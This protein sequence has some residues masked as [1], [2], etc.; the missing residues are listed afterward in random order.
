MGLFSKR[1][2]YALSDIL[3][4][5]QDAVNG[6]QEMLQAQ[7]VQNLKRFWQGTDGSPICQK[8][9]IG[10][11]EIDVPLVSLVS[12]NHLEMDYVEVMFKARIADVESHSVV[13]RL[14]DKNSVSY[15]GLQV[16][17]D[18]LEATDPDMIDITV[19]F[20]LKD[21]AEGVNQLAHQCN[22]SI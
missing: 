22:K 8:V 18:D 6:V 5:L 10:N 19:R 2:K 12:H 17:L 13:N 21:G 16:E 11:K 3:K 1:P 20:K 9:K 14:N 7:Q 15:A 4:G